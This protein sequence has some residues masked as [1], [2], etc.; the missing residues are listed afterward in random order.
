[1]EFK[2]VKRSD[3]VETDSKSRSTIAIPFT[4]D[5]KHFQL[6]KNMLNHNP[7]ASQRTIFLL[8]LFGQ[9][10]IF[11]FLERGLAVLMKVCQALVTSIRQDLYVF[12]NV[13]FLLLEKLE[14]ML[15]TMTKS[16]GY[17]FSGFLV[18]DQL[19]FLGMSLLYAAVVR[20]L[21]FFGRSTGCSLTSTRITSKTVSLGWSVFLPG[22]R[23]VF[24]LIRTSSTLR[25]VRQ[26]VASLTP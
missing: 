24:E 17:N 23:N 15:A 10:M 22:R 6:S 20:F 13:E 3:Q 11:G 9:G 4:Q 14:V 21:A 12:G 2:V 7:L 25:I 18:V 16:G 26:T 19:C 5:A 1:M 8:F